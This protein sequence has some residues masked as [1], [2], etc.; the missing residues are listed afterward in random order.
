MPLGNPLIDVA[1]PEC[2]EV[3]HLRSEAIGKRIQ[4]QNKLCRRWFV[5]EAPPAAEAE[6]VAALPPALTDS[7]SE[8]QLPLARTIEPPKVLEEAA[9][10]PPVADPNEAPPVQVGR[11]TP[12]ADESV[13]AGVIASDSPTDASA[14]ERKSAGDTN[15]PSSAA[16]AKTY[17]RPRRRRRG[18]RY[19]EFGALGAIVLL[20]G[21]VGYLQWQAALK[22]PETRWQTLQED[23]Q[24]HKW[25]RAKQELEEYR[26]RF[27]D[28][29]YT[30]DV[31]FFADMCDAGEGIFSQTGDADKGLEAMQRIFRTHRDSPAYR[32]YA[33][34]LYQAA[35]RLVERFVARAGQAARRGDLARARR[36]EADLNAARQAH[37]L[38]ATVAESM[39][40]AWVP[41]QTKKLGAAIDGAAEQ[42]G[43]QLARLE[44]LTLFEQIEQADAGSGFDELNLRI[45]RLLA[46]APGLAKDPEIIRQRAAARAAE[47]SHVRFIAQPPQ[48]AEPPAPAPAKSPNVDQRTVA[49]VWGQPQAATGAAPPAGDVITS[50]ARGILY[51]FDQRG[52]LLWFRR[53]GIDSYRPPVRLEETG[54]SPEMLIATSSEENAL[55]ALEAA[56]G[57]VL[58][59]YQADGE[60]S[61]PLTVLEIAD[62]QRGARRRG[63]LPTADGQIHVLEL[64]LGKSLGRYRLGRPVTVGGAYDPRSK[65]AFFPA[66]SERVFALD[67]AAID[68]ARR[69]A[70]R[71]VLRT[72][73]PSGAIRSEPIVVGQYLVLSES[74]DLAHTKL[75]VFEIGAAGFAD[76]EAKPLGESAVKGWSWFP[77]QSTPDRITLATDQ[78]ALGLFGLNLDNRKEAIYRLIETPGEGGAGQLPAS[79]AS[80]SLAVRAD[81]YLVWVM[82]GGVLRKLAIDWFEQTVRTVWPNDSVPPALAG[83][84]LHQ[85]QAIS[86]PDEL[87]LFLT[88]M[89]DDG[90][91]CH[92]TAVNGDDGGRLWQRQLGVQAIGDP[93]ALADRTVVIDASGQSVE[94]PVPSPGASPESGDLVEPAADFALP[95]DLTGGD[96]MRLRAADGAIYLAAALDGEKTIAVRALD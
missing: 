46:A 47:A 68:D 6:A 27:P 29:P 25:S 33:A 49:V 37:E 50:L 19:V 95:H 96:V 41:E 3:Y 55:V 76:S 20:A 85:A 17:L 71:S 89:T 28:S 5:A 62:G 36:A 70:C 92:A 54:A 88:T 48:A 38:L 72:R 34:D 2:G 26:E 7:P 57:K 77:P 9:S 30:K 51:A 79:G 40:D 58:W 66:D 65:L 39:P 44:I 16:A 94:I 24:E 74:S 43:R 90:S 15:K 23:Y 21:I 78:G 4:C 8:F 63:L 75:R 82:A 32:D 86:N 69:P 67:P 11:P 59:S 80:K 81:D 84:P 61:A 35:A 45:D 12:A 22:A 60:I 93:I 73:H 53:V 56:T 10:L 64:T 42:V 91:R 87:L 14:S 31:S 18:L 13:G 52:A 83:N 1:C